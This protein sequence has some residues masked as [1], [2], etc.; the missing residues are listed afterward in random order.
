MRGPPTVA[1]IALSAL[2]LCCG[3]PL[4]GKDQEN[5]LPIDQYIREAES[6][7]AAQSVSPGSLYSPAGLLGDASRDLQARQVDDIVTIVVADRASAVSRG[8]TNTGRKSN[9]SASVSAMFGAMPAAGAMANLAKL[10]G[11]QQLQGQGETSRETTLTTTISAR[12]THVLPNGYLVV[13]GHKNILINSERQQVAVRGV[14]RWSDIGSSNNVLSDRLAELE[15]RVNGK[16]VV[17]D[18]I[19]RPNI[20]YRILLGILPF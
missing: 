15:I 20:L 10:G 17:G 6:R 13:Q 8:V 16:G 1:A 18:A 19:R 4:N 5:V 2:I 7:A 9:A 14:V 3:R 11:A 12:V